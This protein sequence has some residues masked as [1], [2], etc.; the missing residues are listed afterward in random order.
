MT[1]DLFRIA[2]FKSTHTPAEILREKF[3]MPTATLA[4]NLMTFFEPFSFLNI[5][6]L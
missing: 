1:S 4:Q 2:R 3:S 5:L 6:G